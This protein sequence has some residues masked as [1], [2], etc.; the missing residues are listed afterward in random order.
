I[1]FQQNQW[2]EALH[3]TTRAMV[4]REQLGYTWGTANSLSNLGILAF[5]AGHWHK[6]I[7][8]FSRSLEKREDMGDIEG[9][10]ITHNNLGLAYRGQGEFDLSEKHFRESIKLTRALKLHYHLANS[11]VGLAM[12]LV[13]QQRFDEAFTVLNEGQEIAQSIGA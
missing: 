8:F 2:R 1:Y 5:V 11:L 12:I 13:W 6:A 4:L 7:D 3:H 10:V 9:I